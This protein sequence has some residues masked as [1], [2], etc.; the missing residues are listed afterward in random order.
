MIIIL[1]KTSYTWSNSQRQ[2]G[3]YFCLESTLIR[4]EHLWHTGWSHVPI[5]K[6]FISSQQTMQVC[7]LVVEELDETCVSKVAIINKQYVSS[8][9]WVEWVCLSNQ[10]VN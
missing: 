10:N 2:L 4:V 9:S 3:Q 8:L 1:L 6:H 7:S 5:E